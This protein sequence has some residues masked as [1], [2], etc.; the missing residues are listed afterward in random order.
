[1]RLWRHSYNRQR[2]IK[3]VTVPEF[4]V[5]LYQVQLLSSRSAQ[6]KLNSIAANTGQHVMQAAQQAFLALAQRR[7]ER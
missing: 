1:M 6:A 5:Y 4:I 2:T 7:G 3:A